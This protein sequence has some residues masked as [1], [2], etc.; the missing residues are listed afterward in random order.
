MPLQQ[1]NANIKDGVKYT[2]FLLLLTLLFT[3]QYHMSIKSVCYLINFSTIL[4][5]QH[6]FITV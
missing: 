5:T 2:L 3:I 4:I 6:Q 1:V